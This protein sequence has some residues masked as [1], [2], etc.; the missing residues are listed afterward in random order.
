MPKDAPVRVLIQNPKDSA[1]T[2]DVTVNLA[3]SDAGRRV[4]IR[5]WV[6]SDDRDAFAPWADYPPEDE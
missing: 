4:T 5:G 6:A 1:W 2:S 3:T